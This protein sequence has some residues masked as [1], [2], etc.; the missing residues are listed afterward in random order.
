MCDSVKAAKGTSIYW[1][2]YYPQN[3]GGGGGAFHA[4][5]YYTD[6]A[7][8]PAHPQ[9]LAGTHKPNDWFYIFNTQGSA[10]APAS[11]ILGDLG[12]TFSPREP[13]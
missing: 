11:L 7:N 3:T 5:W 12:V 2:R 6:T 10:N 8:F 13:P 4:E 9:N 1:V